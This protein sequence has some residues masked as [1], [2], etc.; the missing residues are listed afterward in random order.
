MIRYTY[1]VGKHPATGWQIVRLMSYGQNPTHVLSELTFTPEIGSNL[2]SLKVGGTEYLCDYG[3]TP[4]GN[5][6]LGTPILYPTPDRVRNATF[7]FDG[8]TFTLEPNAGSEFIH[9]LVREVPWIYDPPVATPDGI[10]ATTRVTFEQGKPYY[11]RFPI[12][13]TLEL[14]YTLRPNGMR[15]D[16]TVHN[17]DARQRLPFGLGIH[18]YFRIVGP[19][20]S[21]RI[22]VPARKWQE[23]TRTDLL[24]TGRL[25]DMED[26]PADLRTPT[27][28]GTLDLDDVFWGLRPETPQVI[29]YD[30]IGKKMTLT[31]SEFFTHSA[32]YTPLGRPFFCVENQ[33]CSTD[34]HN[35]YAQGGQEVAHLV[36]LDPGQ[37]L[38]AW[39][40]FSVGEQ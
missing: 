12:R 32:V 35:L 26:G 34:A 21:V 29:F 36:I 18:P 37:S 23:V 6:I 7:T 22:Q 9:G 3:A 27:S 39:V 8:R 13:N 33:S 31:A 40:E 11:D 30:H 20:E 16:F 17:E 28:L 15:L 14:T 4:R 38:A 24:P 19:R 5:R 1:Q 2:I 25:L 10:A